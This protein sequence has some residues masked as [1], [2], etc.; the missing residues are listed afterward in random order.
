MPII[1]Y[2]IQCLCSHGLYAGSTRNREDKTMQLSFTTLQLRAQLCE[3]GK[4]R[5]RTKVFN[6]KQ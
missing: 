5:N 1:K 6:L 4:A 2:T 3:E